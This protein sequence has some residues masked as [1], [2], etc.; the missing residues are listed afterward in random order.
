MGLVHMLKFQMHHWMPGKKVYYILLNGLCGVYI[1]DKRRK[2]M[3]EII[4]FISRRRRQHQ[5]LAVR[6]RDS[7]W[8][9]QFLNPV[10]IIALQ[11]LVP[12][13]PTSLNRKH[14]SPWSHLD[15]ENLAHRALSLSIWACESSGRG[16]SGEFPG[17][18][19]RLQP[20]NHWQDWQRQAMGKGLPIQ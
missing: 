18:A 20:F 15:S 14:R 1:L 10:S 8:Q 19:P 7:T 6:P 2:H 9:S 3:S 4:Y 11:V 12:S 5:C 13:H 17:S 16:C